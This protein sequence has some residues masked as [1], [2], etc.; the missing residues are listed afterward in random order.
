[1]IGEENGIWSVIPPIPRPMYVLCF[2]SSHLNKLVEANASQDRNFDCQYSK[3]SNVNVYKYM[4]SST[5]TLVLFVGSLTYQQNV[6]NRT[7][8][9]MLHPILIF[10]IYFRLCRALD[11]QLMYFPSESLNHWPEYSHLLRF[12]LCAKILLHIGN[13]SNELK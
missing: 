3:V 11:G 6:K 7:T 5:R 1:M 12:V 9:I 4:H 2:L 8:P 13:V 10:L